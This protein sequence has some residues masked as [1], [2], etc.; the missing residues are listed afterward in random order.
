LWRLLYERWLEKYTNADYKPVHD[1]FIIIISAKANNWSKQTELINSSSF[2]WELNFKTIIRGE[3]VKHL[4]IKWITTTKLKIV[5]EFGRASKVVEIG[6]DKRV[7][8]VKKYLSW[9]I[10]SWKVIKE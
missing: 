1:G 3:G 6:F 4:I 9:K 8:Q 5:K 2:N 10:R 7:E